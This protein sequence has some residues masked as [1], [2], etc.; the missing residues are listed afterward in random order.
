MK[1]RTTIVLFSSGLVLAFAA[2]AGAQHG[3]EYLNQ[4][5]GQVQAQF[6][7][8]YQLAGAV[9]TGKLPAKG[10]KVHSFALDAGKC[11]RAIAVGD[12]DVQN[13]DVTLAVGRGP[14]LARDTATDNVA[15]ASYCPE[16]ATTVDAR[17]TAVA[18]RGEYA[19]AIYSGVGE[20]R[21]PAAASL[22]GRLAVAGQTHA[23]GYDPF[24]EVQRG[25][26]TADG[27]QSYVVQV[28]RGS[29]YRFL[30][31]GGDGVQDIDLHAFVG[32]ARVA[33]DT[34]H[35]ANP[36]ASY[37]AP[38]DGRAEVR[39]HMYRGG[40]EF[41]YRTFKARAEGG[42]VGA[43]PVGGGSD[44]VATKMRDTHAKV[45]QGRAAVTPLRRGRLQTSKSCT[46]AVDL[47][48][49]HCYT[50]IAVGSPSAH[51]IDLSLLDPS[52]NRVAEDA[53]G[54]VNV[55]T[56]STCPPFPGPHRVTVRMTAGYGAFGV[57]VFGQ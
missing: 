14:E 3:A 47:D 35:D 21:A 32:G 4:R 5:L 23:R 26:L 56:A 54:S 44:F 36:I 13:L 46:W 30:A 15:V 52:G 40:G 49:G 37:C 17:V 11:Y 34:G 39:L 48:G 24:G 51:D 22:E 18:G 43:I 1:P 57:Q 12:A 53:E 55:R 38:A 20:G 29:C 41:A 16:A 25:T 8:G 6:A 19:I 31:V 10:S 33:S 27:S 9:Q 2:V 7:A 42:P 50:V 45:G 28:T